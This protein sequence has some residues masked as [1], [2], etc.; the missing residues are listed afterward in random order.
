MSTVNYLSTAAADTFDYVVVGGGTAGCLVASRLA[1]YLPKKRILLI[2]GGPSDLNDQ[3]VADIRKWITL[4]GTEYDYDYPITE[5]YRGNSSIRH[6]RAK[7]LGG[8]SSHNGG[9]SLHTIEH[10]CKLYESLGAKGFSWPEMKRLIAKLR[11]P[12][13]VVEPQ[14]QNAVVSDWIRATSSALNIP[15]AADFNKKILSQNGGLTECV[16]YMPIAYDTEKVHR[17]SASTAY[18]HPILRGEWRRNNLTILTDAWVSKLDAS[19]DVVT[20]VK[21]KLGSGSVLTIRARDETILCAGAIDTPKLLLLSGIGPKEQ[22]SSL[23]IPVVKNIPGVGSNL[24]DHVEA[25][26][27]WELNKPLPDETVTYSDG[28]CFVRR[29]DHNA[30]GDGATPD[31]MFHLYTVAQCPNAKHLSYDVPEH[32]FSM[33]PNVPRPRSRGRLYLTSSDPNVKPALDFAYFTDPEGYDEDTIV[34]GLKIARKIAAQ[35]P[36]KDWIKREVAPGPSVQ[37]DEQLS[38]Y[39]RAVSST[40]F[41]PCGTTKMG[42]IERDPSAVVDTQF[43]L[44]GMRNLRIVDAGVLPAVSTT[45]PML[46][47][48]AFAERGAEMIAHAAGWPGDAVTEL[49]GQ[50]MSRL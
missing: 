35:S 13:Q 46:T 20:G 44:R 11:L 28:Y 40:L 43:K 34:E 15:I 47:I 21:V 12:Y 41:H 3:K 9:I 16:G 29:N 14:H 2:E 25:I 48:L 4:L 42:D 8:C 17:H 23:S 33:M 49:G 10:D 24:Q 19:A 50:E 27:V 5:Q 26:I 22:L 36:L 38:E 6:S 31:L 7:V 18:I 1:E 45:N 37:T 32:G 30:S 39:G